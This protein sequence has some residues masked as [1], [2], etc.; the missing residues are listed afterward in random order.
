MPPRT[1]PTSAPKK[2]RALRKPLDRERILREAAKLFRKQGFDGTTLRD[3]AKACDCLLGSLYYRY[4]TKDALLL[5]MM[6]TALGSGVA[7][8]RAAVD[9]IDDPLEKLRAALR[10]HANHVTSES[11]MMVAVLYEWRG[12]EPRG[13]KRMVAL[14][15]RYER[16]W[17]ELLEQAAAAGAFE[18]GH[19]LK[20]QRLLL[21]G[22]LNWTATW[23]R[24]GGSHTPDEIADFAW[25]SLALKAP[26]S[27]AKASPRKR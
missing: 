25:K 6:E 4:P 12:L 20:L 26:A 21:I 13:R 7:L 18:P 1:T 17:D 27:R 3:I 11:D 8:L 5:D 19:D 24:P 9:E 2:A 15:D 16:V 14:R 22:G 10:V 23:Y